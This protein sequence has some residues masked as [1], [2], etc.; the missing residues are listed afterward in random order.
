MSKGQTA[1]PWDRQTNEGVQAFEA[2]MTY[3]DMG[4]HRSHAKVSVALGKSTTLMNRWAKTHEWRKR[5]VAYDNYIEQVKRDAAADEIAKMSKRHA[6]QMQSIG[7]VLSI[8][9]SAVLRHIKDNPNAVATLSKKSLSELIAKANFSAQLLPSVIKAERLISGLETDKVV[10]QHQQ[11]SKAD[12]D[13]LAVV[14][15]A[16]IEGDPNALAAITRTQAISDG[17]SG[18]AG[19]RDKSREVGSGATPRPAKRRARKGGDGKDQAA[20]GNDA[21]SSRKKRTGK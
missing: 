18:R 17:D 10:E 8:P 12:E 14:R 9:V 1:E 21:A 4:L 13:L 16:L 11:S 5:S 19:E 7:H 6:G 15:Q 20:N 2:F 3:R